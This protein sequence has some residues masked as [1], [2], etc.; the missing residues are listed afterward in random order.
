M[1][2]KGSILL[3]LGLML[4][5]GCQPKSEYR[6]LVDQELSTGVTYD[7]LFAGLSFDMTQRDFFDY[8]W[9]MN[10]K[11]LFTNG[12]GSQV[13]YDVS[14]N[15]S[16]ETTLSFYPKYVNG[17]MLEMPM[18][19]RYADWAPW[20]EASSVENLIEE[21]K[22][23][24]MDWYGGNE[25]IEVSSEDESV[26]IWVKIDGNRQIRLGKK[27]ISTALVT[28]TNLLYEKELKSENQS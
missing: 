7:S 22:T 12:V 9:E 17:V 23:V 10:N 4:F 25:F 6:K 20:N 27:N 28:I 18:E 3:G 19:F 11:G 8:C 1:R 21:L 15:F 5:L 2:K 26:S 24:L 14:D 16:K 13:L